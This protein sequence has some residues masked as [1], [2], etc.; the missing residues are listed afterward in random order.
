[1]TASSPPLCVACKEAPT[2]GGLQCRACL[3]GKKAPPDPAVVEPT[4]TVDPAR[5]DVEEADEQLAI[6]EL[7]TLHG[8]RVW[9]IGQRNAEGTQDAGVADLYALHRRYGA[10]WV[11]AKRPHNGRLKRDQKDFREE[12]LACRVPHVWGALPAVQSYLRSLT[13]PL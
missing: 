9:R 1:M 10:L 4:R 8:W 3:D 5:A 7:L 12:C 6:V 13:D 2:E 11:E